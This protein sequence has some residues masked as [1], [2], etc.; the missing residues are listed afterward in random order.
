MK[1]SIAAKEISWWR[2]GEPK[3]L[4]ALAAPAF[5]SEGRAACATPR[6]I[7]AG[8][9]R[10]IVK[11]SSVSTM[12]TANVRRAPFRSLVPMP[13]NVATRNVRVLSASADVKEALIPSVLL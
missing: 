8:T 12:R 11:R 2:A 6:P 3:S 5:G 4:P 7:P 1:T 9:L 13:V 10:W